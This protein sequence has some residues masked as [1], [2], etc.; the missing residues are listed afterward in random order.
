M[1]VLKMHAA[2]TGSREELLPEWGSGSTVLTDLWRQQAAANLEGQ[3][4]LDLLPADF[5]GGNKEIMQERKQTWA[6]KQRSLLMLCRKAE[7]LMAFLF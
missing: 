1:F 3:A 4:M 6:S 7:I 2:L 5:E